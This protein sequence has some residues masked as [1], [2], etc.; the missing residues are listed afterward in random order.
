MDCK[1]RFSKDGQ[2]YLAETTAKLECR[3]HRSDLRYHSS[4]KEDKGV[5][6]LGVSREAE[7]FAALRCVS[8]RLLAL[9][10]RRERVEIRIWMTRRDT[11]HSMLR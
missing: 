8:T 10:R 4:I 11:T 5:R 2:A 1:E 7:L 6:P 3:R 9:D